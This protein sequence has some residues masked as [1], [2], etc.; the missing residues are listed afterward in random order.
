MEINRK[1]GTSIEHKHGFNRGR[2]GDFGV[3]AAPS[4]EN[5]PLPSLSHLPEPLP[6]P[7]GDTAAS[8]RDDEQV[9][10]SDTLVHV[11]SVRGWLAACVSC[12]AA[13]CMVLPPSKQMR[14]Q[15]SALLEWGHPAC[16]GKFQVFLNLQGTLQVYQSLGRTVQD[17]VSC[18][19]HGKNS[20]PSPQL[21][22]WIQKGLSHIPILSP[23]A[24]IQLLSFV[25]MENAS[26]PLQRGHFT[27]HRVECIP[28]IKHWQQT[29]KE[30]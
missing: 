14:F 6:P 30:K 7:A 12:P 29:V 21:S 8:N 10:R 13:A 25:C 3:V 15:E 22:S 17:T 18:C 16:S 4:A 11:G 2:T 28:N 27:F 23:K 26:T 20:F 5:T 24:I 1:P 9:H 19:E